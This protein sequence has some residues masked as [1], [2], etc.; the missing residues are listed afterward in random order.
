MLE[1]LIIVVFHNLLTYG[2]LHH[3][4][5]NVVTVVKYQRNFILLFTVL[6]DR[7]DQILNFLGFSGYEVFQRC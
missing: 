2:E 1:T 3:N 7:Y 4:Q 6:T 5:T